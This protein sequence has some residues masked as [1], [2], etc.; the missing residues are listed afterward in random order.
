MAENVKQRIFH[1]FWKL[2]VLFKR[3]FHRFEIGNS[4]ELALISQKAIFS[5]ALYS[6]LLLFLLVEPEMSKQPMDEEVRALITI[7][8]IQSG[9]PLK[10]I[11]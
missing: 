5:L 8:V 4:T 11:L 3:A 7:V 6:A 9:W 10:F 1:K 2:F